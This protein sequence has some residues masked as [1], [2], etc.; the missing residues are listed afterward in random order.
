MTTAKSI[1]ENNKLTLENA[2]RQAV[3]MHKEQIN[4]L[5]MPPREDSED[6]SENETED[7]RIEEVSSEEE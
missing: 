3:K 6:E 1:I 2:I 5:L 4:E 7:D